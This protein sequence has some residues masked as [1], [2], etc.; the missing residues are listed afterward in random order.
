MWRGDKFFKRYMY[1]V[2]TYFL[3]CICKTE[4]YSFDFLFSLKNCDQLFLDRTAIASLKKME[5][6]KR[7]IYNIKGGTMICKY[8]LFMKFINVEGCNKRGGW[9]NFKRKINVEG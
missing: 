2:R 4:R 9:N 1:K 6:T 7:N 5:E 3:H 8:I